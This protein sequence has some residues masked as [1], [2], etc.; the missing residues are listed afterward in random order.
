MLVTLELD[1]L[2]ESD[3][4]NPGP[5]LPVPA[6]CSRATGGPLG[7]PVETL[8]HAENVSV[9]DNTNPVLLH[10]PSRNTEISQPWWDG[11]WWLEAPTPKERSMLIP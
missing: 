6:V 3:L 5:P 8:A 10:N 9:K 7:D 4:L 2:K 11:N 1:D